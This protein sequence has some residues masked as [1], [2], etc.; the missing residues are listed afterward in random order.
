MDKTDKIYIC[1]F[2]DYEQTEKNI[3]D[4]AQCFSIDVFDGFP[5]RK[6]GFLTPCFDIDSGKEKQDLFNLFEQVS[7]SDN[8][9]VYIK[10]WIFDE[11]AFKYVTYLDELNDEQTER[12]RERLMPFFNF[13]KNKIFEINIFWPYKGINLTK[14]LKA[15][16][17]R[18]LN[19]LIVSI[20]KELLQEEK[21]A[22]ECA[23]KLER[24]FEREFG[25]K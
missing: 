14:T 17:V 20:T 16:W 2:D 3:R 22:N 13:Y 5:E 4:F 9:E 7:K 18:D 24:E 25:L 23:R 10:D 11:S 1:H 12:L 8:S 19:Y 6:D 21:D 15:N